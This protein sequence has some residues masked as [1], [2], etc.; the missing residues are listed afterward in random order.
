MMTSTLCESLCGTAPSVPT[1]GVHDPSYDYWIEVGIYNYSSV[2]RLTHLQ[3]L[4]QIHQELQL[5]HLRRENDNLRDIILELIRMTRGIPSTN[6]P[7]EIN[8][9]KSTNQEIDRLVKALSTSKSG[10]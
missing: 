2:H 9:L 3:K 6:V 10:K 4:R 7:M 8:E 5:E 1:I